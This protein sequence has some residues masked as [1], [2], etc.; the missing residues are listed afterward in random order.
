MKSKIEVKKKKEA[1]GFKLET[2]RVVING[3]T[4]HTPYE[5]Q[6]K[7]NLSFLCTLF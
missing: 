3:P 6:G 4:W 5:S 7:K 1:C 2:K